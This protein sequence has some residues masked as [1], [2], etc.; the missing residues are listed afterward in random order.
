MWKCL[1][2][3][4]SQIP[5][6]CTNTK[7]TACLQTAAIRRLCQTPPKA[8]SQPGLHFLLPESPP[9]ELDFSFF[10]TERTAPLVKLCVAGVGHCT[11]CYPGVCR[12]NVCPTLAVHITSL[13]YLTKQF[14]KIVVYN[15]PVA[16]S[17]IKLSICMRFHVF[18]A[19]R[20]LCLVFW[21]M[22]LYKLVGY[23]RFG[24]TCRVHLRVICTTADVG[25][26]R[27]FSEMSVT[28]YIA[29]GCHNIKDQ[30]LKDKV[31]HIVFV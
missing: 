24:G 4:W 28:F 31:K 14:I 30:N 23:P 18:T 15:G 1:Y 27:Y 5:A 19:A 17:Q 13:V 25:G 20:V 26:V 3:D 12:L 29:T 21:I 22:A 11:C 9:S 8:P 2:S 6:E 16:P 7:Q 10:R